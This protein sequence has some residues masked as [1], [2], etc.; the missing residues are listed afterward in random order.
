MFRETQLEGDHHP[1]IDVEIAFD[2]RLLLM[3]L[4]LVSIFGGVLL[5][6]LTANAQSLLPM[7]TSYNCNGNG[8]D[9][10]H[11][12]GT[13]TWHGSVNGS[14]T[15]V[16]VV[17]LAGG[18]GGIDNEMWLVDTTHTCYVDPGNQ[19]QTYCWVEGGYVRRGNESEIWFWADD[20]LC[21]GCY[22]IEHDSGQL[23]S[24]D[25]G[26]GAAITI[27]KNASAGKWDVTIYG[28]S[29]RYT[30]QSTSNNM[31]PNYIQIG[32]ELYGTNSANAPTAS[33]EQN[34]WDATNGT[35]W[36][37][38]TNNGNFNGLNSGAPYNPP[39]SG[40]RTQPSSSSTGGL[41][42]TC[43]LPSSGRNPC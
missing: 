12:Y 16:N 37:Y 38:Q 42:Y 22:Y 43:T 11:C 2:L 9:T 35:G 31:T 15:D 4:T 29:S 6:P 21:S 41:W 36:H 39:W 33:Y 20:R 25:Y 26:S 27:V 40:W 24:G 23:L 1:K 3:T 30:G 17:S 7:S 8:L 28:N 19:G 13:N 18:D 10:Q 34:S 14:Y 5:Q 32:Q